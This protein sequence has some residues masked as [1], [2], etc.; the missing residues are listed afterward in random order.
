MKKNQLIE[1][2]RINKAN[3]RIQLENGHN[4]MFD[5]RI[6]NSIRQSHAFRSLWVM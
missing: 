5:K 1:Y 4:Q 2:A 3:A 6:L